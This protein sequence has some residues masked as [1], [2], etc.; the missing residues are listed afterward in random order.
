MKLDELAYVIGDDGGLHGRITKAMDNLKKHQK[1]HENPKVR[2]LCTAAIKKLDFHQQHPHIAWH[3]LAQQHADAG[4][5]FVYVTHGVHPQAVLGHPRVVA[6][7]GGAVV[8]GARGNLCQSFAHGVSSRSCVSSGAV[9]ALSRSR[10]PGSVLGLL[11][12]H[13]RARTRSPLRNALGG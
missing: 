8:A 12:R 13:Q 6:Q 10:A 7:S 4:I 9:D 1:S 3:L 11:R 2:D 5:E